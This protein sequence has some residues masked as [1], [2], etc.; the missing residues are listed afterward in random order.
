MKTKLNSGVSFLCD[1]LSPLWFFSYLKGD[2]SYPALLRPFSF[3]EHKDYFYE[4]QSDL[5]LQ[6]SA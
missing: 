3:L 2:F 5:H 1:L 6:M 4:G